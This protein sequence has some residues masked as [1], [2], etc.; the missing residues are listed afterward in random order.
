LVAAVG[1]RQPDGK[2]GHWVPVRRNLYAGSAGR[3]R[4]R[5]LVAR[6]ARGQIIWSYTFLLRHTG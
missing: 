4:A 5:G 2:S 3:V 1:V 6:D